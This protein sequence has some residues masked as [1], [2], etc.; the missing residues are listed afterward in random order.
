MQ[1]KGIKNVVFGLFNQ[2][3]TIAFGLVLPRM[4]IM[5]YGSEVNGLI[6]SINQL[7]VYVALLEAGIGT[8]SLQALYKTIA[9]NDKDATNGILSATHYFYKQTGFWYFIAVVVL[10]LGYPLLVPSEIPFW[11]VFLV[12]FFNG[13]GGVVNYLFQ[14]VFRIFLRAEGKNY[15]LSNI[16]TFTYLATSISK[17]LFISL[18]FNIVTIQIAYF[19][20]TLSQMLFIVFYIKKNYK[21][22][23]LTVTPNK[24]ALST[25]NSVII[26]QIS[27]LVF[28]NTDVLILTFFS[29]L[30]T[31]SVY[32]LYN[33]FFTM[34]KS[35]LFSFLDGLQYAL[36]QTFNSDF[37]KFK[38]MQ[39][40]FE[41]N[42]ITLTFLLYTILYVLIS[43]FIYLYTNDI[44]D[45]NYIS[46]WIPLLF[47]LIYL[48]QGARGPMQLVSEYARHFK[49]TRGQAIIEMII[50]LSV[51]VVGVYL[52]GIYGVL[53][54]TIAALIYR[55]NAIIIYVNKHILERNPLVTYK[56]W[57]WCFSIFVIVC[58]VNY[59]ITLSVRSYFELILYAIPITVII[60]ILYIGGMYIFERDSFKYLISLLKAKIPFLKS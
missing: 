27:N 11:T 20:I 42:Y 48:L 39:D 47:T 7:F 5:S 6:S 50:N 1:S 13:L 2:F 24:K 16:S 22:I 25:K 31:V 55:A 3:I 17:I 23:D 10:S 4:F 18:G 57:G 53:F 52:W 41:V 19:I 58:F 33:S 54:G 46:F 15:L 36:G 44:K 37:K 28:S 26:H 45:I 51:S 35:V 56:R 21:W 14:G 40:L 59:Y 29:G 34:L 32:T 30:K 49:Q 43:P 12:I 8:A 9:E 38:K 60:T